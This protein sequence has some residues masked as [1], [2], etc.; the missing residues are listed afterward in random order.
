MVL[1]RFWILS[2]IGWAVALLAI[3]GIARIPG[4][5][6]DLYIRD[7]YLVCSKITLFGAVALFLLLPLIIAAVRRLR[8]G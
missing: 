5:S 3:A 6:L 4:R 1:L 7:R 2:G 8:N